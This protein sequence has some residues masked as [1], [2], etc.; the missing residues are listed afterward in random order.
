MSKEEIKAQQEAAA[1]QEA[2]LNGLT[3]AAQTDGARE[4]KHKVEMLDQLTEADLDASDETLR[5][6][7][8]KDIPSGNL[9]KQEAHELRHYLDV[10]YERHQFAKPSEDQRMVGIHAQWAKDDENAGQREP[11]TREDKILDDTYR[12]GIAARISKGKEGSLLGLALR[13]INESVLRRG[14]DSDDSGGL[15]GKLRR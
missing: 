15:L 12:Q 6:L 11:P 1:E 9:S 13:S 10:M 3:D 14:D 2:L 8:T 5:N 4:K 7:L